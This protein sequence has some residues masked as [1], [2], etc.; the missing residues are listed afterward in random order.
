MIPRYGRTVGEV[1]SPW[2]WML[3]S[4]SDNSRTTSDVNDRD[5]VTATIFTPLNDA[6]AV[7]GTAVADDA[8]VGAGLRAERTGDVATVVTGG[9][10]P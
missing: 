2:D 3:T 5:P 7:A 1:E 6:G 4:E 9:D 10:M 8:G